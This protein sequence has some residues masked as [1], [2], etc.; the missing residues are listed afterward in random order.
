MTTIPA[1]IAARFNTALTRLR[2]PQLS[3]RFDKESNTTKVKDAET[4]SASA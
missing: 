4:R 1:S 2:D 3:I